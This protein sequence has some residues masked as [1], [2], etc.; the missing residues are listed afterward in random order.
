MVLNQTSVPLFLLMDKFFPHP[1]TASHACTLHT[2]PGA[3]QARP[4]SATE[5]RR[6]HAPGTY[7]CMMHPMQSRPA[8]AP[9]P[10]PNSGCHGAPLPRPFRPQRSCA[11]TPWSF[12]HNQIGGQSSRPAGD[13][14]RH[15]A[16]NNVPPPPACTVAR[17][18]QPSKITVNQ[19]QH[20]GR[21]LAWSHHASTAI[22]RY[23]GAPPSAPA[24]HCAPFQHRHGCPCH[25]AAYS[26]PP[27]CR[28]GRARTEAKSAG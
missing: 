6:A 20:T 10:A 18:R 2:S 17:C 26:P 16:R 12:Y 27:V 14:G 1:G 22:L 28:T 11:G 13:T 5:T 21:P 3:P 25:G 7:I 15:P 23:R 4:L 19:Q 24:P 8:P 9:A